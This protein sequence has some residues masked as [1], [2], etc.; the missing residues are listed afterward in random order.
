MGVQV[1]TRSRM[2]E[3][4]SKGDSQTGRHR[5][6]SKSGHGASKGDSQ[7][8]RHRWVGESGQGA[9]KQASKEHS[10]TVGSED[11][12]KDISS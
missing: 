12:E 4:V 7:T 11:T 10:Q 3:Q 9:H 6:V 1:R 5:W 8:G 2:S